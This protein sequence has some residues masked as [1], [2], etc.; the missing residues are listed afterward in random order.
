MD[1]QKIGEGMLKIALGVLLLILLGAIIGMF[2]EDFWG[3]FAIV[4]FLAWIGIG[5]WLSW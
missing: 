1:K 4:F 2:T 3:T 5:M